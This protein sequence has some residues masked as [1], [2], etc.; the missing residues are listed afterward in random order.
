MKVRLPASCVLQ[1]HRLIGGPE[2]P[3]PKPARPLANPDLFKPTPATPMAPQSGPVDEVDALYRQPTGTPNRQPSPSTGGK[4]KKW[5]PL[6]SVAPAP[7]ADENDPFSLGDSDDEK[8]KE[9]KGIDIRAEDTARLKKAASMSAEEG[10]N[11]GE[12]G[13]DASVERT[14]SLEEA[15]Q[16]GSAGTRDK[17]AEE[18]LTGK[19]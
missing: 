6:T 19:K 17:I 12:K 14:G 15:E 7:E 13:G 9:A 8:E 3:P 4:S 10:G 5:Q 16:T 11:S 18:L 2:T 1:S